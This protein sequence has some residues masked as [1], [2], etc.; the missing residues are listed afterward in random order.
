MRQPSHTEYLHWK[1]LRSIASEAKVH[2]RH[3]SKYWSRN[4][5]RRRRWK[6]WRLCVFHWLV[7]VPS[8]RLSTGISRVVHVL[9]PVLS[10]HFRLLVG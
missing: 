10:S 5:R 7:V 6:Q 4:W 9:F 2:G 1:N 8:V 3:W